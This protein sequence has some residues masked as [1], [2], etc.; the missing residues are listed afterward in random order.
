MGICDQRRT[1]EQK[2]SL[3]VM[4]QATTRPITVLLTAK[5]TEIVELHPLSSLRLMD[6]DYMM[7][8][9]CL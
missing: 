4:T 1:S 5:I 2:I 8:Q 3:G 6:M 7:W 9:A